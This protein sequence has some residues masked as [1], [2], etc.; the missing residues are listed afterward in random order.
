M[1]GNQLNLVAFFNLKSKNMVIFNV[2]IF[3]EDKDYWLAQTPEF[4]V[5]WIRKY[6]NQTNE[7]II[8][9][10]IQS[11][12]ITKDVH[13]LDCRSKKEKITIA[14]IANVNLTSD[15]PITVTLNKS[16]KK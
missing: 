15:I 9:E 14:E 13:C 11:P 8:D 3:G 12:K 2:E 6:T 4:K 10:F 7:S 1:R 16:R 5:E